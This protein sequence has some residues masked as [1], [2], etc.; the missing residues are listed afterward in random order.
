MFFLVN[1]QIG[2][3]NLEKLKWTQDAWMT[4]ICRSDHFDAL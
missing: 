4:P 3:K 1:K 2:K